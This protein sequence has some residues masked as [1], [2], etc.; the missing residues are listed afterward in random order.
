MM[1]KKQTYEEA[2]LELEAVVK[3]LEEGNLTLEESLVYYEKGV[4]LSA[5]CADQLNAAEKRIRILMP[6]A[7]GEPVE[8][9]FSPDG[10]AE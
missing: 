2:L 5:Q 10:E 7:D 8:K 6:G 3:K 9:E 1:K 4:S